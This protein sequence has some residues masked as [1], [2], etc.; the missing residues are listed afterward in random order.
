MITVDGRAVRYTWG[1]MYRQDNTVAMFNLPKEEAKRLEGA[2]GGA[3]ICCP[4]STKKYIPNK[5]GRTTG[6]VNGC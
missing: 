6:V 5:R 4:I 2:S 3:L 1:L